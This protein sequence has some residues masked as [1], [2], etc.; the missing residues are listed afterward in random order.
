[1]SAGVVL[2]VGAGRVSVRDHDHAEIPY[3]RVAGGRFAIHARER[4]LSRQPSQWGGPAAYFHRLARGGM[5]AFR[6]GF[7]QQ[8]WSG[9]GAGLGVLV[10]AFATYGLF[11]FAASGVAAVGAMCVSVADQPGASAQKWPALLLSFL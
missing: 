3:H 10:V 6:A 8:H 7:G 4:F 9:L 1:M 5:A 2:R 11:G